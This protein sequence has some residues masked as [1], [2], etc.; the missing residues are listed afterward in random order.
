MADAGFSFGP[1]GMAYNM[2][3]DAADI[4]NSDMARQYEHKANINAIRYSSDR[5]AANNL[6]LNRPENQVARMKQA[7][8]NPNFLGSI[9]SVGSTSAT[10]GTSGI[11]VPRATKV[12][13]VALA[14]IENL[15]A[16]TDLKQ[17]DANKKKSETK[18]QDIQNDMSQIYLA[19]LSESE[20]LR[21]NNLKQ[22]L[23]NKAANEQLS[24]AQINEA[25]AQ[26]FKAVADAN[27]SYAKAALAREETRYVGFYA[28]MKAADVQTGLLEAQLK[29]YGIVLE[30]QQIKI[31]A[32]TLKSEDN[33]R[34]AQ[35]ALSNAKEFFYNQR[36]KAVDHEIVQGYLNCINGALNAFSKMKK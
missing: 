9:G 14:Q 15:K 36:G 21:L 2:M 6:M 30:A 8:L 32:A 26:A 1:F 31:N 35:V 28:K 5:N 24:Y 16:D 13:P 12:D 17:A 19:N 23:A 20:R 18:G 25:G 7:G 33:L 11:G 29:G 34:K 3:S 27:E 10:G 22:D 4:I